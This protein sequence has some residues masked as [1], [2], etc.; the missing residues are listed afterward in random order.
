VYNEE[1][2]LH[3]AIQG[4]K[5]IARRIVSQVSGVLDHDLGTLASASPKGDRLFWNHGKRRTAAGP[6]SLEPW[7][8]RLH[9]IP[10]KSQCCRGHN[11]QSHHFLPAHGF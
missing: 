9:G 5:R 1:L 8:A 6:G 11:G 4:L 10:K 2:T 3:M 7:S